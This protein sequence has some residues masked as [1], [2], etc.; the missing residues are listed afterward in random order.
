LTSAPIARS[1]NL[2]NDT[3]NS[4]AHQAA[5]ID[6]IR[7]TIDGSGSDGRTRGDRR[8]IVFPNICPHCSSPDARRVI[9]QSPEVETF[10]CDRCGHEWST[11]APAPMRPVP[12]E[13]LPRHWFRRAKK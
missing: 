6:P 2:I 11:P 7:A 4:A 8:V 12:P 5:K 13:S 10:H 9:P 1:H 3:G